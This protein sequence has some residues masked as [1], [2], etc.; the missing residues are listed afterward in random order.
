MSINAK[1]LTLAAIVAGSAAFGYHAMKPAYD[2]KPA[3]SERRE[4]PAE[5]PENDLPPT[6]YSV[7]LAGVALA[8]FGSLIWFKMKKPF[9]WTKY[10][11]KKDY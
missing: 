11:T 3:V 10:I 9:F 6:W 7:A 1:S 5:T 8:G 2:N 4:A